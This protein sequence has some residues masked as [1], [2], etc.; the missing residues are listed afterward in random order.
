MYAVIMSVLQDA[1][2]MYTIMS[3]GMY[4]CAFM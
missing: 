3:G 1:V 4:V 2:C